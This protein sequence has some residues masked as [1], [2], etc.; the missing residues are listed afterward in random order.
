MRRDERKP[1]TSYDWL[2]KVDE[3]VR[4]LLSQKGEQEWKERRKD[5]LNT[6]RKTPWIIKWT[7]TQKEPKGAERVFEGEYFNVYLRNLTGQDKGFKSLT[8]V[9]RKKWNGVGVSQ[10]H[11][12]YAKRLQNIMSLFFKYIY[13]SKKLFGMVLSK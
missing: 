6:A 12:Y 5:L 7:V 2:M 11:R 1:R 10:P 8:I 13:H 4:E 3:R 9:V